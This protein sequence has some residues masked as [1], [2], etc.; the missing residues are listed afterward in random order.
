MTEALQEELDLDQEI[1]QEIVEEDHDRRGDI[2]SADRSFKSAKER[3]AEAYASLNQ[4]RWEMCECP[5]GPQFSHRAY[6]KAVGVVHST[7]DKGVASWQTVV[8]REMAT[9]EPFCDYGSI[10]HHVPDASPAK[11][12][13]PTEDQ[14]GQHAEATKKASASELRGLAIEELATRFGVAFDTMKSNTP[15]I[16]DALSRLNEYDIEGLA[17][18]AVR[19]TMAT[20]VLE[21]YQEHKLR[22]ARESSIQRWMAANRGVETK[23]IKPADVTSMYT[24]IERVMKRKDLEWAEAEAEVRLSDQQDAEAQ[25]IT[26]ELARAARMAI[27]DLRK[28]G[29]DLKHASMEMVKAVRKIE[30]DQIPLTTD[31]RDLSL[32]DLDAAQAAIHLARA[33]LTGNSGTDWDAALASLTEGGNA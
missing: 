8:D 11:G 22:A 19:P 16:K 29:A 33:A 9:G 20:I 14:V 27:L 25:R 13:G 12:S 7:I 17:V 10:P 24:R 30:A 2:N 4:F 21:I 5:Y 32:I 26:N 6:A 3:R 15:L 28:S 23:D 18:E 31:E 1:D